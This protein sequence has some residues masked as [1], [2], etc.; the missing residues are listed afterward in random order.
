[1]S[2]SLTDV[3]SD[4]RWLD[5]AGAIWLT[6]TL[7]KVLDMKQPKLVRFGRSEV[8]TFDALGEPIPEL[9]GPYTDELKAKIEELPEDVERVD[10]H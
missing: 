6:I 3:L 8:T 2:V 5:A 4:D 7:G 10:T 9:S 1:M